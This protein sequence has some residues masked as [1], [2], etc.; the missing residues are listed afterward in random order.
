ME[1]PKTV[2][3]YL[4]IITIFPEHGTICDVLNTQELFARWIINVTYSSRL[5]LKFKIIWNSEIGT[6]TLEKYNDDREYYSFNLWCPPHRPF[7]MYQ[8]IGLYKEVSENLICLSHDFLILW[9]FFLLV[10]EEI[11]TIGWGSGYISSHDSIC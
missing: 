1:S 6:Y 10:H 4:L 11:C 8:K 5:P 2:A 3:V 9:F 7:W